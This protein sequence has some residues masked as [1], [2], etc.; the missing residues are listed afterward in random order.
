[1]ARSLAI[2]LFCAASAFAEPSWPG[3]PYV[4]VRGYGYNHVSP[5]FD[6]QGRQI[7]NAP[8][9]DEDKRLGPSVV[10]KKGVPLTSTQVQHLLRAITGKH[11]AHPRAR[12]WQPHHGF[13]FYDTR[14]TAV[15]WV[16]VCFECGFARTT[17]SV[18]NHWYDDMKALLKLSK[19]LKLPNPPAE[20][21]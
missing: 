4:E 15:A 12:C 3:V 1:M 7:M 17:P 13:V 16:E 10:N 20:E 9:I 6:S 19:E 14:G 2:L 8:L 18:P 11:A 5:V 21:T